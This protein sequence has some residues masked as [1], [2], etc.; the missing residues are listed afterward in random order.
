MSEFFINHLRD[1]MAENISPEDMFD[2]LVNI[3]VAHRIDYVC[4]ITLDRSYI[5]D[6]AIDI[7]ADRNWG[8]SSYFH[9]NRNRVGAMGTSIFINAEVRD[10]L[11]IIESTY[12][13]KAFL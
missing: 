5:A 12:K 2:L 10:L 13:M 11:K 8:N 9:L 4:Y 3:L 1:C 7:S 6:H